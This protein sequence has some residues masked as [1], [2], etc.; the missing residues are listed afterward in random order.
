MR[1]GQVIT[2]PDNKCDL[3]ACSQGNVNCRYV[4]CPDLG[5]CTSELIL[6]GECCPTCMDCGD[7]SNGETWMETVCQRCTCVVRLL[8]HRV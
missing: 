4:D 3:C 6:D 2:P 1:N 5:S 8:V 7:R